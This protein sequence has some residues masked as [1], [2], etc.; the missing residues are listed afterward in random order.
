[1]WAAPS[2]RV[3]ALV[4]AGVV[5]IF[6]VVHGIFIADIWFNV[7]PMLFAGAAIGYCLVWSYRSGAVRHSTG[8]WLGYAAVHVVEMVGLGVASFLLF[9]PRF[10]MAELLIAPDAFDQLISPSMPLITGAIVAGSAGVWGLFGRRLPA[11]GPTV[12]SQ[13]LVVFLLGHQFAFLG[14]VEPTVSMVVAAI[15]FV[16][17]TAAL[18]GAYSLGVMGFTK[19]VTRGPKLEA[20]SP[21]SSKLLHGEAGQLDYQ[22]D[23]LVGDDQGRA[24]REQVAVES[25]GALAGHTRSVLVRQDRDPL[26]PVTQGSM[27][28]NLSRSRRATTGR[29][30]PSP[31]ERGAG[32]PWCP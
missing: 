30:G 6:T 9:R 5:L 27:T 31:K 12:A 10:T 4:G 20:D 2:I 29:S 13:T 28:T 3:G 17:V 32:S 1:M 14:L 23:L 16:A 25:V 8:A 18:A 22:V 24:E 26:A 11:I 21:V 7:V 15:R 19:L